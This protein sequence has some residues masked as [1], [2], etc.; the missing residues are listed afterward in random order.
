METIDDTP[1]FFLAQ[2]FSPDSLC[3]TSFVKSL[4]FFILFSL[5]SC[6]LFCSIF[7][8]FKGQYIGGYFPFLTITMSY[9]NDL[10]F[11]YAISSTSAA[12]C[13]LF[14]FFSS[15]SLVGGDYSKNMGII[16]KI[17]AVFGTF[18]YFFLNFVS[19]SIVCIYLFCF[20]FFL[21]SIFPVF[22]PL[23]PK[24]FKVYVFRSSIVI[25]GFLYYLIDQNENRKSM[26]I[27]IVI[28]LSFA[29]FLLSW[30]FELSQASF[31]IIVIN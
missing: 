3:I 27:Q 7:F 14:V 21:F 10:I 5:F 12:V 26:Y 17:C 8:V 30:L 19:D 11:T 15:A 29:I 23:K 25:I 2:S 6:V 20:S 16:F 31:E 4:V 1:L 9:P 18:F 24:Q 28:F 13:L 22:L